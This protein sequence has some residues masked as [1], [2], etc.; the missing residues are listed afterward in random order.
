MSG[1]ATPA[2]YSG[3]EL[4]VARQRSNRLLISGAALGSISHI[5]AV[6]VAVVAASELL[7]SA[8]LA[9]AA[10]T[11]V[12]IGAAVGTSLLSALMLRRGRRVGLTVGYA[13]SVVG[14]LLA[15]L[16]V[17]E[18]NF[19]LLLGGM[20]LLGLG[21]SSN[22]LSRYA[23][24]DMAPADQRARAIG[25]VVWAA[26]VGAIIGP[27]VVP[28]AAA[29]SESLGLPP[30]VGPF[31]IP[32]VFA[33]AAAALLF[34]KLRPDPYALAADH[35]RLP[36]GATGNGRPMRQLLR[37]PRVAVAITAMIV[38]QVV[39]VVIMTM[40]PLHMIENGHGLAAVG[41]VISGHTAGMF[42]FSPLSGW[43]AQRI[44]YLGAIL[45]GVA[46]L[47]VAALMAAAAPPAGGVVL[48]AALF[49]LGY[50]W[51]LGFVAGSALLT[52]GV[53]AGERTQIEGFADTLVWSS[54]A[55]A[56]L[57]SGLILAAAGFSAL[58]I[59]A[60]MLLVLPV[61]AV[62]RLRRVSTETMTRESE[63]ASTNQAG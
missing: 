12:V 62:L 3:A 48:F 44:G 38:G 10:N 18:G 49:L 39:M 6:T 2:P 1:P 46:V 17:L 51:N 53:Q 5:A 20:G 13:I 63:A 56:S 16:G 8:A 43:I 15:A 59:I 7:E 19:L 27:N 52:T 22:L 30:L 41:F 26:T 23:A 11:T 61:Y 29:F 24:A 34:W 47:A 55:V 32:V 21:N 25:L 33:G 14:A 40:T 54:S 35:A 4:Q 36:E 50:G 58:G 45:L 28:V 9:G 31:L 60:A 57:A 37:E 42:A